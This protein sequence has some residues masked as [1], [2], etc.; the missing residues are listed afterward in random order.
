MF[1]DGM[2]GMVSKVLIPRI[3]IFD[4]MID[5]VVVSKENEVL[6]IEF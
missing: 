6:T 2:F 5:V 3:D 4:V 1:D